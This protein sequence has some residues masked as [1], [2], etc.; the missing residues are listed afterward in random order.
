M[1]SAAE[2]LATLLTD[3]QQA[4]EKYAEEVQSLQRQ[5]AENAGDLA[6]Q[7]S[8]TAAQENL[9]Q[10]ELQSESLSK[11]QTQMQSSANMSHT[12]S[13]EGS[14]VVH[15]VYRKS[16][17]KAPKPYSLG[18]DYDVFA[19]KLQDYVRESSFQEQIRVLR[20]SLSPEAYKAS[21]AI[22]NDTK[23]KNIQSLLTAL[24]EVLAPKPSLSLLITKFHKCEQ[25]KA[26]SLEQFLG[27][28]RC[29]GEEAFPS[30]PNLEPYILQQF[31]TGL[32]AD[33]DTKNLLRAQRLASVSQALSLATEITAAQ[34]HRTSDADFEVHEVHTQYD[35]P[36]INGR[37]FCTFCKRTGHSQDTCFQKRK[38]CQ[39]C[40]KPGHYATHC[41]QVA[42]QLC[43]KFNH[44][45]TQCKTVRFTVPK[46]KEPGF[47]GTYDTSRKND[48]QRGQHTQSHN[49][50]AAFAHPWLADQNNQGN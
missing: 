7:A 28:L 45:A 33:D 17:L 47:R 46:T 26:E 35:A 12:A 31:I 1:A 11:I 30:M 16:L 24:K 8:L 27:R 34:L 40:R 25:Q 15:N 3:A 41:K 36:S 19:E 29:A 9:K 5:E 23:F 39:L 42:C 4:V 22:I 38:V 14:S 44:A 37:P 6:L 10:W 21:K 2:S 13:A 48:N 49:S 43:G 50:D 20:A 18:A 32:R